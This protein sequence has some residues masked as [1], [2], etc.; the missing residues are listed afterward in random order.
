MIKI[1]ITR[2]GKTFDKIE[3]AVSDA[4]INGVVKSIQKKLIPLQNEIIKEG[5]TIELVFDKLENN[6]EILMKDFSEDLLFK[7]KESLSA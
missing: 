2:K 4:V 5:G 7:I 6:P 3:N 1:K